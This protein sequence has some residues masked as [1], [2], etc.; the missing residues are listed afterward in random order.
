MQRVGGK[1]TLCRGEF[2]KHKKLTKLM[3]GLAASSSV[4]LFAPQS[5]VHA[6]VGIEPGQS[7]G[8]GNYQEMKGPKLIVRLVGIN[9]DNPADRIE[10]HYMQYAIEQGQVI[11]KSKLLYYAQEMLHNTVGGIEN[12]AF[13]IQVV[14]FEEGASVKRQVS[15]LNGG[16][17]HE[18]PI[19]EYGVDI[20]YTKDS[21]DNPT[22][23]LKGNIYFK[24]LD[25]QPITMVNLPR[26]TEVA[27]VHRVNFVD[28][29]N[30][31]QTTEEFSTVGSSFYEYPVC[32]VGDYISDD[33]LYKTAKFLFEH[34]HL[35][36]QGYVLKQRI[37]TKVAQNHGIWNDLYQFDVKE[38]PFIHTISNMRPYLEGREYPVDHI[39]ET[40]FVTKTNQELSPATST[41][42][43]D[44]VNHTDRKLLFNKEITAPKLMVE[45]GLK[46]YL[47][48]HPQL[49]TQ[50][51]GSLYHLISIKKIDDYHFEVAV[52][53]K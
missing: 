27:A 43:M 24:R 10:S 8:R 17:M 25:D 3:L 4:L 48:Q 30:Q 37:S 50:K 15:P 31:R 47:N 44:I 23:V 9:I 46:Q 51:D 12:N 45:N 16:I 38:G 42:T 19:T 34:S 40:Y 6:I 2:M 36:A 22:Y 39:S 7:I 28:V 21:D 18:M 29:T 33:E 35:P 26:G 20:P 32:H 5:K 49:L 11:S 1:K 52:D 13:N 41:V 14:A 53:N